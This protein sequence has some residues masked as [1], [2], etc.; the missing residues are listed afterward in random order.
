MLDKIVNYG[1]VVIMLL[2]SNLIIYAANPAYPHL[3]N[4]VA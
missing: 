2:D 1:A 4:L 3:K